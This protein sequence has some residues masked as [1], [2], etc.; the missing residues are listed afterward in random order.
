MESFMLALSKVF[1]NFFGWWAGI[2]RTEPRTY[3]D[4]KL[5]VHWPIVTFVVFLWFLMFLLLPG[6]L[7]F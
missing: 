7:L 6:G 1:Q 2:T 3:L 4:G 5:R